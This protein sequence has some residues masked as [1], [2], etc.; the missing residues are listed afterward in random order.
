MEQ[1]ALAAGAAAGLNKAELLSSRM[2]HFALRGDAASMKKQAAFHREAW[3]TNLGSRVDAQMSFVGRALPRASREAV[4]KALQTHK[5]DYSSAFE[6]DAG[7]LRAC[8]EFVSN[9]ARTKLVRSKCELEAPCW[10]SGSSCIERSAKKGG[11]LAYLLEQAALQEPPTEYKMDAVD[12]EVAMDVSLQSHALKQLVEQGDRPVRHRVAC[13]TERGLKT[14]VVTVSPA[15]CQTLGHS[16][17]KRL[18]RGLRAT[19]GGVPSRN[20][21]QDEALLKLLEGCTAD[22]LVSTDLTRASDLLPLDLVRAVVDGLE[23]SGRLTT[24]EIRVLRLLTGPQILDYD[25]V[26]G[27]ITSSRGILM[28]LPTTWV[29]LSLIHLFWMDTAKGA[30]LLSFP[31]KRSVRIRGAICGDDAILATTAAGAVAYRKIV[32]MCGGSASQGKHFECSQGPLRRA[33]FLERLYQWEVVDG[34]LRNGIR[35]AAIP[36]KGLTSSTLPRDFLEGRLVSCRSFGI[37]QILVLDALCAQNPIL[38]GPCRDYM[39][40]RAP[41]LPRYAREILGL[42]GGFPLSVGGFILAPRPSDVTSVVEVRDSGRSYSVAVQRELD[43]AWRMAVSFSEGGR[44]LAVAEGELQDLPLRSVDSEAPEPPAGWVRVTEDQRYMRTVVPM[45]RQVLS[46]SG[47]TSRRT[48][49]L[50]AADF[51]R[52][53]KKLRA[54]GRA[55]P[56]GL[57][58]DVRLLEREILWRLP[59]GETPERGTSWYDAT[60]QNRSARS[61]EVLEH[62]FESLGLPHSYTGP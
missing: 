5:A 34:K 35:F 58:A 43:P 48:L 3:V 45:Y 42:T 21:L 46:F 36:V 59:N 9:W 25:V 27:Q 31:G 49:H 22:T 18:L 33:V 47:G 30:A 29:L 17:R 1:V 57:P 28:G 7:V 39:H 50:R 61:A 53:L 16:V 62:V 60:E 26:G 4:I 44:E 40:R 19:E 14:R 12:T 51:V 55:S 38:T 32:A 2:G 10:P 15:W 56:T 54:E 41:W 23:R 37:R 11:C 52:T 8:T 24:T 13:I 6:T 20:Q